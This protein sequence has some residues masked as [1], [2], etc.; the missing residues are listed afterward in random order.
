[1]S[2]F[3]MALEVELFDHSYCFLTDQAK[4]LLVVFNKQ[5][6][7]SPFLNENSVFGSPMCSFLLNE[8]I[9]LANFFTVFEAGFQ[10][11]H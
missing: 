1:M 8:L 10:P 7:W 2:A 6:L 3:T 5:N 9:N 11:T 4:R